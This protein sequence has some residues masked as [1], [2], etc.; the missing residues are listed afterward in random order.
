MPSRP[1]GLHPSR[2]SGSWQHDKT[3][4]QR[5]YGSVH[6]RLRKVVLA[7]EPLCRECERGGFVTATTTVDH[8]VPLSRGGRTER[9]NMQ[10]LCTPCHRAKTAGEAAEGAARTR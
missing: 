4:E 7:E 2:R 3:A 5:G 10:G 8:I 1:P 6:R 9:S